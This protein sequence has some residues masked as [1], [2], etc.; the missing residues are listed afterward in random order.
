MPIKTIRST[1][2]LA[3]A[4]GLFALAPAAAAQTLVPVT[5]DPLPF[6][7]S[8]PDGWETE[9]DDEMLYVMGEEMMLIVAA[10]DLMAE[11]ENP[12]PVSETEARRIFTSMIVD[13]DS[14][15]L[16]MLDQGFTEGMGQ[17]ILDPVREIR[18]LGGERAGYLRG[19]I[20]ADG[21]PGWVDVHL[22]M[23]DGIMY[24]LAF[25]V[26]GTEIEPFDPL[27]ARIRES[28]VPAPAPAPAQ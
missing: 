8:V 6:S 28:F 9:Q 15:L 12:L 27:M 18:S 5:G 17:E 7:L 21:E 10:S 20:V 11:E 22:T 23:K 26:Q 4:G 25:M 13:S 14:L 24:M 1:L 2:V 16:A 19:R 3:L